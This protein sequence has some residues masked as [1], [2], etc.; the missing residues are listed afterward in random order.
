MTRSQQVEGHIVRNIVAIDYVSTKD[1]LSAHKVPPV[2]VSAMGE[3]G[4]V[5]TQDVIKVPVISSSAQHMAVVKDAN[6]RGV[7]NPLLGGLIYAPV[8]VEDVVVQ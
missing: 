8:M 5:H 3:A 4:D 1:A 7:T 6:K 2:F